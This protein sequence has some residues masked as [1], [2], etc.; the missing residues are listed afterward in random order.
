M[1]PDILAKK[2]RENLVAQKNRLEKYLDLLDST[3]ED[4]RNR[5]V[6][7]LT[8]HI[9]IEKEIITELSQ[10][11]KVLDPLEKMY[12]KLPDSRNSNLGKLKI[13]I[14]MLASQVQQKSY[15]NKLEVETIVND[16]KAELEE[17]KRKNVFKSAYSH[18]SAGIVDI[19]G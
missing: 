14:D 10:F 7:R 12:D 1:Q 13:S 9:D 6:D 4:I 18:S 16:V 2:I 8:A 11:K 17:A 19:S 15:K 5:D 3:E